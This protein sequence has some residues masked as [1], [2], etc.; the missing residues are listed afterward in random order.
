LK[1]ASNLV[2]NMTFSFLAPRMSLCLLGAVLVQ[3]SAASESAGSFG[4]SLLSQFAF[5]EGYTNLNHGSYGS[6][7]LVV[8]ASANNWTTWMESCP[9]AYF[10]FDIWGQLTAVR[11]R[12]AAY[13]GATNA[14][15]VVFVENASNGVNAVLQSL[16]RHAPPNAKFLYLNT[17]YYMV[18]MVMGFVEPQ[19]RIVVNVTQP[20]S[21]AAVLAAVRAALE[22]N[23]GDV[24]VASFSHI[25]S[26][27][28]VIL[29]AKELAALCR[30]YGVMSL[31][32]GAHALGHI[33]VNV[34]DLNADFWLGNAH[35]WLYSPKGAA[36]LW[37]RQERQP[38]I[39]PTVISWEGRGETHFQLAFS[40]QGTTTYSQYLALGAALDFRQA[41]G[42]ETAIMDYIHATAVQGGALLAKAWGTE[43]LFADTRMFGAL[44]D[45]RVPTT[46]ATLALLI[47]QQLLESTV[48]FS[49]F[50]PVYDIGVVGGVE[51]VFYA[52]VSAQ[53]YTELSDFQKLADAVLAIINAS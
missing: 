45:V 35:K 5:R 17:A 49:T 33:P 37:V 28:G 46:N 25:V 22:A 34:T 53:I 41:I 31:I 39:E 3:P 7:P 14:S 16:A 13:I 51:G 8:T 15:D 24:Y 40:Y 42:G 32:D 52:R 48:G 19:N 9:D 20:I 6:A 12:M 29:P 2:F 50:V 4:H 36:M 1:P 18:K 21:N 43:V 23:K 26:V 10:R 47:A 27:P 44:V 38:L 11:Q 30:E